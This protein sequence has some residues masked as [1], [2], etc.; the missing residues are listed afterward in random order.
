MFRARYA[1]AIEIYTELLKLDPASAHRWSNLGEALLASGDQQRAEYCYLRAIALAP[2]MAQILLDLTDFFI[3]IEQPAKALPYGQRLL[4][5]V[6]DGSQDAVLFPLYHSAKLSPAVILEQGIPALDR[7]RRAYFSYLLSEGLVDEA[8]EAWG[9]VG[10]ERLLIPYVHFLAGKGRMIEA[11]QVWLAGASKLDPDYPLSNRVF[12]GGFERELGESP[13]EWTVKPEAGV[14]VARAQESENW[15]LQIEF[16]GKQ[17]VDYHHVSQLV[18]LEPGQYRL[19]ARAKAEKLTTEQGVGLAFA[20]AAT[21]MVSGTTGWT[22]LEAVGDAG[23]LVEVRVIRRPSKRFENK[24]KGT[25]WIDSVKLTR[26]GGSAI[27]Q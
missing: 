14:K 8:R 2:K 9:R 16:E 1:Q 6:P 11:A 13:F 22:T 12:N 5:G 4:A 24:I 7:P 17:N 18:Y 3:A 10:D 19:A 21:N 20:G 27:R 15:S 26:L 25:V 23:G